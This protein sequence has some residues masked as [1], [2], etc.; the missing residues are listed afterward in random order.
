[1]R[2]IIAGSRGITDYEI[3]KKAI[4]IAAIPISVVISGGARGVDKL[5]ER[6]AKEYKKPCEI[7]PAD[8]D[9]HGKSAG[10]KR[11]QDMATKA[12]ALIAVYDGVS[13]GTA[14]MIDIARKAGLDVFVYTT[15]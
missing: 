1:M 3:V 7:Y 9:T 15:K 6:W 12:D 2:T 5:G 4:T 13:K 10:Y 8:W 14:H 11:N